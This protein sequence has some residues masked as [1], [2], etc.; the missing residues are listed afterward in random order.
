MARDRV[1]TVYRSL[2]ARLPEGFAPPSIRV[3]GSAGDAG[4]HYA[5]YDRADNSITVSPDM[6]QAP[7]TL[8]RGVLAHELGHAIIESAHVQP[9]GDPEQAA[10][11][12]A[13]V[14]LGWHI[15]YDADDLVQRAGPGACG[16]R[17]RPAGL[18]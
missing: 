9:A 5:Y 2:V 7:E 14:F 15:Y 16:I 1:I 10:D 8:I 3:H 12:F 13:E 11:S 17:P 18:R 6:E 4:R